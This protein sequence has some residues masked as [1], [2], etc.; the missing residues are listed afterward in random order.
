MFSSEFSE[1]FRMAVLQYLLG[2]LRFDLIE[3]LYVMAPASFAFLVLGI[4]LF[5]FQ[6]FQ[7][8]DG[9]AKITGRPHKYLAAA[10]LG[11]CVNLLTLAVIKSTSS[12]TFKVVGQVKN[13]VVILVSVVVFGSEIT[14]LQ[15]VGYS[16][17][18]VG[19]A[20]YQRGKQVQAKAEER[21]KEMDGYERVELHEQKGEA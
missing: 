2:N 8:E 17:S 10:F 1:A 7:E 11:F 4:M 19:F 18:M 20:V 9:F 6:T 16:I 21:E 14:F 5:E 12:L 15:V 3:G 13:T